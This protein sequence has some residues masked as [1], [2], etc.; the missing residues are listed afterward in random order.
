MKTWAWAVGLVLVGGVLVLPQE[1]RAQYRQQAASFCLPVTNT[2][3][4]VRSNTGA[5]GNGGA[6][7]MRLACPILDDAYMQKGTLSGAYVDLYDGTSVGAVDVRACVTFG[8]NMGGS[9]GPAN[10]TIPS[11]IGL[12]GLGLDLSVWY[13]HQWEY[14]Y[15]LVNLP[16]AQSGRASA[17]HGY[18]LYR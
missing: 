9:C 8:F 13:S 7:A 10:A 4:D 11:G 1:A 3:Q 18:Y 15:I 17:V 12:T 6:A 14:G 2:Y 16:A 5:I